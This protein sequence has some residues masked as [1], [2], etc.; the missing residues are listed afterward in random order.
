MA[1]APETTNGNTQVDGTAVHTNNV[2]AKRAELEAEIKRL[3]ELEAKT[4][5]GARPRTPRAMMLDASEQEAKDPDNY[6]RFV[7]LRDKERLATRVQDGFT[8]VPDSEGGK[9][10]GDEYA[11]MRQSQAKHREHLEQR[12]A[13]TRHRESAHVREMENA[14][15]SVS[16]MLRDQHGIKVDPRHILSGVN[17][18]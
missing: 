4:V 9:T 14:A 18:S 5:P 15:E 17:Q 12:D 7:N 11:L 3:N 13:L 16:K 6:Y 10:L 1:N 8:K 2:A